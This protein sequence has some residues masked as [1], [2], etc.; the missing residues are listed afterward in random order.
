MRSLD[1]FCYRSPDKHSV[2]VSL[3]SFLIFLV[4]DVSSF[5]FLLT[6]IE[7]S[8]LVKL[9]SRPSSLLSHCVEGV[10]RGIED[11]RILNQCSP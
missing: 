3:P 11:V 8:I 6:W 4:Y 9:V 2:Y 1:W 10:K 5:V 7:Q